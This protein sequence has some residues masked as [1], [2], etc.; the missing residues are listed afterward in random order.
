M[1]LIESSD[2]I[3]GVSLVPLEV[4]EKGAVLEIVAGPFQDPDRG[5]LAKGFVSNKIGVGDA[6]L[7]VSERKSERSSVSS[8]FPVFISVP[9]GLVPFEIAGI[10]SNRGI[11]VENG[12]DIKGPALSNQIRK[13]GDGILYKSAVEALEVVVLKKKIESEGS[14]VSPARCKVIREVRR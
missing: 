9:G 3:D 14:T 8:G 10:Q 2:Y 6:D 13:R 5:S 11:L 1:E 4:S 12:L 7:I